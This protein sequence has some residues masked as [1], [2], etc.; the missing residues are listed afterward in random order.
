MNVETQIN[1][2]LSSNAYGVVGASSRRHKF[3]NKVLRCYLQNGKTAYP[4]N[5]GESMIE[6]IASV[7]NVSDLPASVESISIITPA[8]VTE[9][10]V[11]EAIRKGIK[12]IWMQPGAESEKAIERC[13]KSQVNVIAGGPCLLVELGFR[14]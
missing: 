10:I 7:A 9:K 14:D 11:E 2:F 1:Q 5:P 8:A 12:N 13:K 4:V 6:G 3:G